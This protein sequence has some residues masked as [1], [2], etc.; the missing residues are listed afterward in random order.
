MK[1]YIKIDAIY[2][3]DEKTKRTILGEYRDPA[4]EMLKDIKWIFT[5]KVDGTN[6]IVHWDGHKVE[7]GG[8]TERA[9]IPGPLMKRLEELFSGH[10]MEEL[11]EQKFG[12]K[13]VYIYGEGYGNKIQNSDYIDTT[14]FIVFDVMINDVW[15]E[16][17]A[18]EDIAKYFNCDIVPVVFEGTLDEGVEYVKQYND[19]KVGTKPTKMEGLVARPKYELQNK[20]GKRIITKIKWEDLR[21]INS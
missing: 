19:S 3:R 13:D 4:V 21:L 7:F 14:D 18:V 8:R 11:F 10:E 20:M 17:P 2:K 6:I 1:Y 9:Q 5:E 12:D 16:R 15:L